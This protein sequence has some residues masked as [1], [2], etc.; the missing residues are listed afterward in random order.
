MAV[1]AL[2]QT[3]TE[4][5]AAT[6]VP[7]LESGD[8]LTRAEFERRYQLHPEIKKAELIEGVVYVASPVRVEQQGNPHFDVIAWLGLYRAATPG[9]L[10]SDNATVRL[11]LENIPQPDALLRLEPA[12]G[13]RSVVSADDYLEGPPEL[14]VAVGASSASQDMNIKKRVYARNGVR[15]YIIFQVYERCVSWFVLGPSGYE[16]LMPGEDGILRSRVFPGL[17]LDP[18]A[19]WAGDMRQV[20]AVA[21]RGIA[22]PEYMAFVEQLNQ[23]AN[24]N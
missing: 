18:A 5:P 19:F 7:P 10:G 3:T 22:A 12:L 17:W 2:E 21:Q 8:H 16:E 9:V 20:M 24:A 11:D 6:S 1:Q 15:E 13:G 14:V 4:Q 23:K